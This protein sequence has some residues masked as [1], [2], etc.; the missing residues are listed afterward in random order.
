MR[1]RLPAGPRTLAV[2][3][4]FAAVYL[5]WGSTYLAIRIA[6]ET[7]PPFMMGGGRF[8]VAGGV[9]YAWARWRGAP[10]PKRSHWRPALIVGGLLLL[11]GNGGVIWAEQPGRVSSGVAA[12]LVAAVPLWMVLLN[13]LRPGGIRPSGL[14]VAGVFLGLVGVGILV[15]PMSLSGQA[16]ID[17]VGAMVLIFAAFAWASGSLYSRHAARPESALVATAMQMLCGGAL[18]TTASVVSGEWTGLDV[19]V[20]STPSVL[21]FLYLIVFGALI[22]FTA[23]IW[24]LQVSTPA[25]VSTYAFVNPVVAVLLGWAILSEPLTGRMVL[26]MAV[27]VAGVVMIT[28]Q[29]A[30]RSALTSA[31]KSKSDPPSSAPKVLETT[32]SEPGATPREPATAMCETR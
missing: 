28:V 23:Y 16:P 12:L 4:A 25:K 8:L 29:A 26:A 27:I 30:I 31:G 32:C 6:V 24:L 13:W 19:S 20:F 9:L 15:D 5:I 11:C 7:I 22:G 21:A 3:A 14:E 10:A 18:L 2:A 17:R 1:D